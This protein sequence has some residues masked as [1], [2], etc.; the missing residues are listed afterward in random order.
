M[1]QLKIKRLKKFLSLVNENGAN[2]VNTDIG[3]C[4]YSC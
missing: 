3:H 2:F 1:H 4:Y